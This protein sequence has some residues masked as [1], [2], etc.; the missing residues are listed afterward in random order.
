MSNELRRKQ[1]E[2]EIAAT[3]EQLNNHRQSIKVLKARLSLVAEDDI[4]GLVKIQEKMDSTHKLKD[5]ASADFYFLHAEL[6]KLE[7]V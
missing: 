5:K 4:E 6:K 2:K 1:I 7:E 3:T